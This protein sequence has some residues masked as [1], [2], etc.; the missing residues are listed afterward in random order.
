M[1]YID[2][3]ERPEFSPHAH[4]TPAA[5]TSGQLNYQ[6]CELVQDFLEA[7]QVLNR[8]VRY[9]DYNACIGALECAKQEVYR[10]LI[11]PYE[12]RKER[13]NGDCF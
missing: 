2:P 8:Q 10:K 1:P 6:I 9:D 12:K 5:L 7:R 4:G 11:V 13:E 3:S